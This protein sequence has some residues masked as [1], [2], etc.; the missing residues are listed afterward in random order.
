M[1]ENIVDIDNTR[2]FYVESGKGYPLVLL[3]GWGCDSIIFKH[4]QTFFS[5][6]F[7]VVAIDFP[8]FGKSDTPDEPWDIYKYANITKKTIQAL[9]LEKPILLG[10]SFGGRVS[11]I[12][13]PEIQSKKIILTGSAGIKPKRP[14]KYY[15]KVYSYKALKQLLNLPGLKAKREEILEKYRQKAGSQDYKNAK[16]IMKQILVKVVNEDL[17]HLMPKISSP[18]LLLWGENDTATPLADGKNMEKLIPGS[19][20]VI[21]KNA[22]HYCFIEKQ[23]EFLIIANN[24]LNDEKNI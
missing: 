23:N 2:I 1:Q 22:G 17:R 19:G 15:I 6:W 8:G 10:H 20:L 16:P 24:F 7:R 18:T 9:K 3:H 4:I 11:L 14:L 5:E 13:A 12:I 21:I